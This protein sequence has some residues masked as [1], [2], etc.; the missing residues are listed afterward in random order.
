M[1][2]R[3]FNESHDE[4][5]DTEYITFCFADLIDEGAELKE[6]T[7]LTPN[8]LY[9]T[10]VKCVEISFDFKSSILGESGF[11]ND[12]IKKEFISRRN[13]LSDYIDNQNYNNTLLQK[14]KIAL[15]QLANATDGYPNY[16]IHSVNTFTEF[17]KLEIK[18]YPF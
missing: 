14:I 8:G 6:S 16:K 1:K 3:K 2:I 7:F 15:T 5:I 10:P 12:R 9:N 18:I 4:E 17:N 13:S 11:S